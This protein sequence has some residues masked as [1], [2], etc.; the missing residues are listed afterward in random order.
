MLTF[1]VPMRAPVR[2]GLKYGPL[3]LIAG[4]IMA[5]GK[6]FSN[7]E[8]DFEKFLNEMK[9]KNPQI[10]E[11]QRIARSIWWD[12]DP[13]DLDERDRADKSRVKQRPYVYQSH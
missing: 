5:F 7:Y 4:S 1:L 12:K 6:K 9:E 8:S 3:I 13:I 2:L 10:E 11:N